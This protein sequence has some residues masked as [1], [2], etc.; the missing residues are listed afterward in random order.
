[1]IHRG[2]AVC[3][4][5][6]TGRVFHSGWK[7][8]GGI[9]FFMIPS[10]FTRCSPS[11]TKQRSAFPS[12]GCLCFFSLPLLKSVSLFFSYRARLSAFWPLQIFRTDLKPLL[13]IT[14]NIVSCPKKFAIC[15]MTVGTK[16]HWY[17]DS[18]FCCV[19]LLRS[20]NK[21]KKIKSEFLK[22]IYKQQLLWY[23]VTSR[24]GGGEA[25]G[26]LMMFDVGGGVEGRKAAA[27]QIS[28][29]GPR[30]E[31]FSSRREAIVLLRASSSGLQPSG[32]TCEGR[33]SL[34]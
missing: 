19:Y 4:G 21:P 12:P 16:C 1:M 13:A 9:F 11:H 7:L 5:D 29:N 31:W 18:L 15:C 27:V 22:C 34:L 33:D 2:R 30:F 17:L 3:C 20:C 24:W 23:D 26:E 28:L 14:P 6:R 10:L 25:V 8:G 32:R